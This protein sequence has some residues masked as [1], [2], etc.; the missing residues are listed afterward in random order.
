M[1]DKEIKYLAEIAADF[2]IK[3]S[4]CIYDQN[5]LFNYLIEVINN[6]QIK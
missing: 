1:S 2:I 5:Y 6:S 3:R 4:K